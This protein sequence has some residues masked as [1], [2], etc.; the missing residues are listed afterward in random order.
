MAFNQITLGHTTTVGTFVIV[1][2]PGTTKEDFV[3][4]LHQ[5]MTQGGYPGVMN[6]STDNTSGF[7]NV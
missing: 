4:T 3:N 2:L 5:A 1:S 6:L 7:N